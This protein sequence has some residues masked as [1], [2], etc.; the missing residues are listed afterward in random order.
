MKV[1]RENRRI[2]KAVINILDKAILEQRVTCGLLAAVRQLELDPCR[3]AFCL[4]PQQSGNKDTAA[5]HIQKVLLQAFCYEQ[6][7][8]IIQVDSVDRLKQCTK[9]SDCSCVI[10]LQPWG[11]DQDMSP[12]KELIR[13]IYDFSCFQSVQP[14]IK[15]PAK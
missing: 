1:S 14:V 13:K 6:N 8:A 15:L 2:G 5:S 9:E 3:I 4:L 12:E 10:V 7:I 11:K